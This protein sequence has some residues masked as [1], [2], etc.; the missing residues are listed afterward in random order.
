MLKAK[1][2][3]GPIEIAGAMSGTSLD[4]VDV[5]VLKTDGQQIFDFGESAYHAY[6]DEEQAVLT[7]ALGKWTG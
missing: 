1:L 3:K 4:G 2:N 5:A 7:A 6:S